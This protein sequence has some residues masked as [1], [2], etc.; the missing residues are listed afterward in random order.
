MRDLLVFWRK[1]L[2]EM[3]GQDVFYVTEVLQRCGIYD[4]YKI[5]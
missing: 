3:M 2:S 4:I 5:P 1:V